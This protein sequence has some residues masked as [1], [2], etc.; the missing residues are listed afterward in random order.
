MKKR[1]RTKK[2][3]AKEYSWRGKRYPKE[4]A[5]P[6]GEALEALRVK[7]GGVIKPRDVVD[8]ARPKSSPLHWAFQWDDTKA[9]EAYRI[10]QARDLTAA[11]HVTVLSNGAE[12]EAPA[13][14]NL[15]VTTEGAE[16]GST[17][18]DRGYHGIVQ[19]ME[20]PSLRAIL[21]EQ[22]KADLA[23]FRKRYAMLTEL[24][25][26]FAAAERLDKAA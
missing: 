7:M 13:Y 9:A 14:V 22:A 15:T 26:V 5:K 23:A 20:S 25:E 11:L 16:P 21:L 19:T 24:A 4:K 12:H 3:E 18:S 10:E 6:T 1:T 2:P 17:D 8:T